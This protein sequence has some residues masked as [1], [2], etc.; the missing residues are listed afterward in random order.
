MQTISVKVAAPA[1][2]YI[3]YRQGIF[4]Q[5]DPLRFALPR[6]RFT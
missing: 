2:L 4:R 3:N 1:A 5:H 6:H